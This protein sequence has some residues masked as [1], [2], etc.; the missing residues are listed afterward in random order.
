MEVVYCE[1]DARDS[2][3]TAISAAT[4]RI[5]IML[6]RLLKLISVQIKRSPLFAFPARVLKH[7]QRKLYCLFRGQGRIVGEE[8]LQR[9]AACLRIESEHR[10]GRRRVVEGFS[11]Y[12]R[13]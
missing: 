10:E 2:V 8:F 1:K 5:W 12:R 4:M 9:R 3:S 13:T 6:S 7:C 11:G